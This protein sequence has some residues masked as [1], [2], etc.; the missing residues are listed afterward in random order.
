M[1]P[2]GGWERRSSRTGLNSL[3]LPQFVPQGLLQD[4]LRTLKSASP[5]F[6]FWHQT[7]AIGDREVEQAK[8]I[9]IPPQPKINRGY[10]PGSRTAG[11]SRSEVLPGCLPPHLF[12]A[13][14][15]RLAVPCTTLLEAS[16]AVHREPRRESSGVPLHQQPQGALIHKSGLC[17]QAGCG[18]MMARH[19][20]CT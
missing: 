14:F 13:T 17:W 15:L 10:L 2:G 5:V 4:P 9:A 11:Q 12:L 18:R 8:G 3:P 1:L 19:L 16:S 6:Q 20:E 7:Y